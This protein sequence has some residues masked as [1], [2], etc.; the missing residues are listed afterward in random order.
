MKRINNA[1]LERRKLAIINLTC[2][3]PNKYCASALARWAGISPQ[4]VKTLVDKLNLDVM[5][6][7][8]SGWNIQTVSSRFKNYLPIKI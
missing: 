7:G 4:A 2:D 6:N 5:K 1:E 3:Y 8:R